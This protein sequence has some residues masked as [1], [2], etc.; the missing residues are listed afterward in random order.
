MRPRGAVLPRRRGG[1]VGAED[2]GDVRRR[3]RSGEPDQRG[4]GLLAAEAHGEL[5][6]AGAEAGGARA[7]LL[8]VPPAAGVTSES[9]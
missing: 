5:A 6:A 2:W 8:Q 3:R 4:A 9:C 1:G 7:E